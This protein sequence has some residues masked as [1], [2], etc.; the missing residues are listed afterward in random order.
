MLLVFFFT[1]EHITGIVTLCS[2]QT[3]AQASNV[4]ELASA[5]FNVDL[6][7]LRIM[8]LL[9]FGGYWWR[10]PLLVNRNSY[11]VT[12]FT[13]HTQRKRDA[14]THTERER[15]KERRTHT[16]THTERK[17]EIERVRE[18]ETDTKTYT[19]I[20]CV[21]VR[22]LRWRRLLLTTVCQIVSLWRCVLAKRSY[23]VL[24]SQLLGDN[25]RRQFFPSAAVSI[26]RH[27]TA[28]SMYYATVWT[29]SLFW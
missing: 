25:W 15:E 12:L 21:C 26:I 7:R 8:S 4:V 9:L 28:L 1:T 27:K 13:T 3:D 24:R 29:V 18:R 20:V 23:I 11:D 2:R 10:L 19:L 17:R 6:E 14:H 5:D 16:H 22:V